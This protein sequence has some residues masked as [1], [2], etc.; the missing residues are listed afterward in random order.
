MLHY[1]YI[2]GGLN[3]QSKGVAIQGIKHPTK[4]PFIS[5]ST[6]PASCQNPSLPI[7]QPSSLPNQPPLTQ[8][9]SSLSRPFV[10]K[11][12]HNN[13][14]LPLYRPIKRVPVGPRQSFRVTNPFVDMRQ[15]SIH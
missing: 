2:G 6:S 3:P 9:S 8:P 14:Q 7:Q 1:K 11:T 13:D 5:T 10:N 12:I 4:F 15:D